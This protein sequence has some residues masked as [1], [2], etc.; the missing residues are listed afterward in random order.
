M[1]N[2]VVNDAWL[3]VEQQTYTATPNFDPSITDQYLALMATSWGC[4]AQKR[5]SFCPHNMSSFVLRLQFSEAL[6]WK[7]VLY[8][9]SYMLILA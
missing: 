9:V 8:Y 4:L 1:N 3:V 5:F 2:N 6:F 7:L